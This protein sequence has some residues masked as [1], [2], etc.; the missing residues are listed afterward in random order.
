MLVKVSEM[1]WQF[2]S[3]V[4]NASQTDAELVPAG[5]LPGA[6]E[7]A[8]GRRHSIP[9]VEDCRACH[10][11]KRTE[12]LG[13][14]ALQLSDDRDPGAPHAELVTVGTATLRT[15]AGSNLL[16]PARPE[17]VSTPPRIPAA[18]PETRAALGY[19][20]TNCGS[21]HNRESS[22]A[23]LGLTF[24]QPAYGGGLGVVREGLGRRTK[25][26]RPGAPPETTKVVDHATP[27]QSALLL[28]MKSRKPVSQ[29]PPLGTVLPDSKA[30]DLVERAIR[31]WRL[32][33]DD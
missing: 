7:V 26:D 17:L 13:F 6:A 9:S 22:I 23:S 24:K 32:K 30:L 16:H 10:D 18:S 12:V 2:A 33:I 20:S 11:S 8:P 14:T 21:C 3:Y 29:M 28:R 15:L 1:D 31:N 5:G 27:E 4:W 19:L 25:W